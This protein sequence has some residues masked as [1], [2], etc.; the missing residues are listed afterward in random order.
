M[1]WLAMSLHYAQLFSTAA[2]V[3][4]PVMAELL[5]WILRNAAIR[6]HA[7]LMSLLDALGCEITAP[8]HFP[9]S[10]LA[11]SQCMQL[12]VALRVARFASCNPAVTVPL[13]MITSE[14]QAAYLVSCKIY[15]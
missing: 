5:K 10:C 4:V 7:R 2:V 6:S 1:L 11:Q 8:K 13:T 9:W 14:L 3:A 15:A 12:K